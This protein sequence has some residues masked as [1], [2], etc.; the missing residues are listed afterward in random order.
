MSESITLS[1]FEDAYYALLMKAWTSE[2]FVAELI[3]DP[4]PALREVGLSVPD[5]VVVDVRRKVEGE[6]SLEIAHKLWLDGI[7]AGSVVIV[8]PDVPPVDIGQLSEAELAGVQ[9]GLSIACCCCTPC[10]SCCA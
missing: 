7:A 8:V 9:G 10:C 2:D 4:K 3:A 5:N 1:E 6:G